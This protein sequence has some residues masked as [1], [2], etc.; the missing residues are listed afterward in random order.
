M[1]YIEHP[2][3]WFPEFIIESG[4]GKYDMIAKMI[5]SKKNCCDNCDYFQQFDEGYAD[6]FCMNNI[7]NELGGEFIIN[8]GTFYCSYHKLRLNNE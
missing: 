4:K 5:D 8:S 7:S 1:S 2:D 3:S 6:G